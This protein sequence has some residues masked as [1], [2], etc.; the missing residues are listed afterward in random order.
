MV[1]P[2][3]AVEAALGHVGVGVGNRAADGFQAQ[4]AGGQ[5][6]HIGL[7]AHGGPLP[8]RQ[9]DQAHARNLRDLVRKLALDNALH[10]A[11]RAAFPR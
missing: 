4:P 8:A 9:A 6:G 5:R 10:F 1:Q 7:D 3:W 11:Q 2:W